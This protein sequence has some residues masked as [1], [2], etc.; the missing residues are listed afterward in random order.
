MLKRHLNGLLN[1]FISR[2]TNALC[3][4]FSSKIQQIKTAARGFR[5]F[6]N[7]RTRILYFLGDL[8]LSV[9]LSH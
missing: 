4:G 3:E 7:Y 6:E 2:L 8:D 5:S 9:R 1:H